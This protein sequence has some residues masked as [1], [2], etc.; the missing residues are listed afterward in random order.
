MRQRP[1]S[2][3]GTGLLVVVRHLI[4]KEEL[5]GPVW[6]EHVSLVKGV[7]VGQLV[8]EASVQKETC[9]PEPSAPPHSTL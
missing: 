1:H 5:P 2:G 6:A 3:S 9:P 8:Q 4:W 7:T